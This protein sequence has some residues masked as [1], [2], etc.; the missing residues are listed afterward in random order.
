MIRDLR[1]QL[2]Q[3]ANNASADA[4]SNRA[5]MSNRPSDSSAFPHSGFH[6]NTPAVI[7]MRSSPH[8]ISQSPGQTLPHSEGG[9]TQKP[10]TAPS[11]DVTCSD[12]ANVQFHWTAGLEHFSQQPQNV[13]VG[14]GA[15]GITLSLQPSEPYLGT[16]PLSDLT[17]S[18]LGLGQDIPLQ[19]D[20]CLDPFAA[21]D[22]PF[23]LGQDKYAGM[24]DEWS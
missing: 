17:Q 22:I 6:P 21:F 20:D 19:N 15:P 1:A 23:W 18:G 8:V 7:S 9:S 3:K 2:M 12:Q 4:G 24:V 5:E 16:L 14:L 13:E 10:N 11:V